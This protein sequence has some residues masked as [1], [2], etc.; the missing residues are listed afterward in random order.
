[1]SKDHIVHEQ[2][3][4]S[5]NLSIRIR[6]HELFS[7]NKQ[8]LHEWIFDQ[9]ELKSGLKILECG[10]GPAALWYKN[11]DKLP[12]DIQI[13]L[14]D[15]SSGM[16]ESAEEK[17]KDSRFSYSQA[18]IQK[19]IPFTDNIFDIVITNHMLYDLSCRNDA[20]AEIKRVLKP[21]GK[22]YASTIGSSNLKEINEISRQV[23]DMPKSHTSCSFTLENG[24]EQIKAFF[25]NTILLRYHNALNITQTQPLVD[26]ILSD[27]MIQNKMDDEKLALMKK[28]INEKIEKDG[29]IC[30]T[31]DDGIFV[32]RN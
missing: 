6:L 9:L 25:P 26:Y 17:L 16:L 10:C 30:V 3:K 19:K 7:K 27:Q 32:S 20:F 2:Y 14:I 22:Y 31:K 15:Q 12:S 8:G 18:D 29:K 21:G 28:I 5:S 24:L 1:M 13:E 4:S 23:V 11:I